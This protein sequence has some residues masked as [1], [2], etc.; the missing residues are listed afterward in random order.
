MRAL[1]QNFVAN[2]QAMPL[3][4]PAHT[5]PIPADALSPTSTMSAGDN[6]PAVNFEEQRSH[7]GLPLLE[8]PTAPLDRMP[9]EQPR[10][11]DRMPVEENTQPRM[12]EVLAT[13]QPPMQ[14][15]TDGFPLQRPAP[16][17][18]NPSL[19]S[20]ARA[21]HFDRPRIPATPNRQSVPPPPGN[22]QSV[23]PP[24]GREAVP[25]PPGRQVV[26]PPPPGRQV[27]PPPP[28]PPGRQAAPP[29]PP[30][31]QIAGVPPHKQVVTPP[32]AHKEVGRPPAPPRELA[33]PPPSTQCMPP[34]TSQ[35]DKRLARVQLSSPQ[36]LGREPQ[37]QSF[38][39]PEIQVQ[40]VARVVREPI[41]DDE[42]IRVS[43]RLSDYVQRQAI[44]RVAIDDFDPASLSAGDDD[45]EEISTMI[46]L[47]TGDIVLVS[48]DSRADDLGD[49]DAGWIHGENTRTGK[50]GWFP[51]A[52]TVP[53]V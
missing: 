5:L 41:A 47:D 3:V 19:P 28:P 51:E 35:T 2:S 14:R 10:T 20:S 23:P 12:P 11:M 15:T 38:A 33:V 1:P 36:T 53:Q 18:S 42:R 45:G 8:R 4:Q 37:L 27:V 29:P 30:P 40:N 26:P 39:Q 6:R 31:P 7:A 24:P 21:P 17:D 25:P 22:R 49:N 48:E 46:G 43:A 16:V 32:L 34:Q 44:R 50:T 9:V 13:P 52:F